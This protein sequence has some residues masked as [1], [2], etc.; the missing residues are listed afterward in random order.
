[1]SSPNAY[2]SFFQSPLYLVPPLENYGWGAQPLQL[3]LAGNVQYCNASLALQLAQYW[4]NSQTEGTLDF[5]ISK[6]FLYQQVQDQ[7]IVRR[8][9]VFNVIG[10]SGPTQ[11]VTL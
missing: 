5:L 6:I 9:M 11:P 8:H 7:F 10:H 2:L 1:M 4:I 3:G